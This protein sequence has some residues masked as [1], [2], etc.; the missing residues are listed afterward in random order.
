[1]QEVPLEKGKQVLKIL[2]T[3][4]HSTS[5]FDDFIHYEKRQ[6]EEDHKRTTA[7]SPPPS[8]NNHHHD[9]GD[10]NDRG[11]GHRGGGGSQ[12]NHYSQHRDFNNRDNPRGDHRGDRDAQHDRGHFQSHGRGGGMRGMDRDHYGSGRD[13][14]RGFDRDRGDRDF[15]SRVSQRDLLIITR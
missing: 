15:Y 8:N 6:E 7:P 1:M 5:I 12:S 13:G 10:R 9:R 2:H 4:V 14:G 11:F 3:F